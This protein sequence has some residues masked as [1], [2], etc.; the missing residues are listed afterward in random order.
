MNL[1]H[2]L[3]SAGFVD[4]TILVCFTPQKHKKSLTIVMPMKHVSLPVTFYG[5]EPE[6]GITV[7]STVLTMTKSG[8]EVRYPFPHIMFSMKDLGTSNSLCNAFVDCAFC[9]LGFNIL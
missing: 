3:A 9:A 5:K 2:A 1:Q 4:S 6:K 7:P 8:E